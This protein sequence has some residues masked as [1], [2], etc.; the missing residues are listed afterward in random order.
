MRLLRLALT[1]LA[2]LAVAACAASDAPG[3]TYA[4]AASA[5][6]APSGSP[7]AEPSGSPSAEPTDAPSGAPGTTIELVASG[8][9]FDTLEITVPAGEPFA[10]HLVNDDPAGVP[11]DVD[12][13]TT[14]GAVLQDTDTVDGGGEITYT[15]DPLDAGEYV[16][17][18]SIHPVPNMTGTLIVE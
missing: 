14:E 3:W 10:I 8:I 13:E 4:P 11:H 15:Y 5:T 18:C 2:S 1:L 7:S 17:Q 12:I 6:P 16:F 9:E